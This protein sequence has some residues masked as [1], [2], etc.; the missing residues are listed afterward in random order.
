[1]VGPTQKKIRND[2]LYAMLIPISPD[3][4]GNG[5]EEK[6]SVLVPFPGKIRIKH[7]L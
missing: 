2:S 6:L 3:Y 7:S 1:M 4:A 5:I